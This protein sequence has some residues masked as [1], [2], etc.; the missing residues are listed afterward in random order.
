MIG[1][2]SLRVFA[3]QEA[4][5]QGSKLKDF[6]KFSDALILPDILLKFILQNSGQ[7]DL[8][9]SLAE[10]LKKVNTGCNLA[11]LIK[12]NR[13]VLKKSLQIPSASKCVKMVLKWLGRQI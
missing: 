2:M 4:V 10:L 9:H 6:S 8:V 11:K 7:T 13:E 5:K 1:S 12:E 3:V